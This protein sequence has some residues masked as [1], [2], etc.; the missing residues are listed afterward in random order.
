MRRM[1]DGTPHIVPVDESHALLFSS[2]S[3]R[4]AVIE[5]KIEAM[6]EDIECATTKIIQIK[7]EINE[8]KRHDAKGEGT[9]SFIRDIGPYIV[10]AIGIIASR[11]V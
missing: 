5:T 1:G 8:L 10:L 2:F 6:R 11:W 7:D 3:V 4:L 9:R